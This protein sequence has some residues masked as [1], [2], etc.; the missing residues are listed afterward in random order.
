[1]ANDAGTATPNTLP[2]SNAE[3]VSLIRELLGDVA[4]DTYLALMRN[5]END[6]Q[7]ARQAA[8]KVFDIL[9]LTPKSAPGGGHHR[10]VGLSIE[11]GEDTAKTALLAL[12]TLAGGNLNGTPPNPPKLAPPAPDD[13]DWDAIPEGPVEEY[14]LK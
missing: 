5:V 11:F 8:D 6:P 2:A 13:S 3:A 14:D 12:S 1:M 10:G 7:N 9:G 4:L